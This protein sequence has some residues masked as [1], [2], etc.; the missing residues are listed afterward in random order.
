MSTLLT[1]CLLQGEI[2]NILVD[3]ER[4][5]KIG[6]EVY[7]HTREIDVGGKIV[8]PGMIDLHTH[9]RDMKQSYKEDWI[10]AGRA[11]LQGGVTTVFDMPNTNPPTTDANNYQTKKGY[12]KK[13]SVNFGLYAGATP[14]NYSEMKMFLDEEANV[15]GIKIFLAGSSSNEVVSNTD[16]LTRFF[17][18]ATQYNK[19]VLVHCESQEDIN[20]A[21]EKYQGAM[22]NSVQYHNKIRSTEAAAKA[23]EQVLS[24]AAKVKNKLL[25]LHVSSADEINIIKEYKR[26]CDFPLYCEVT[27]HHLLLNETDLPFCGN[28]GKVN[29]PI[30]TQADNDALWQALAD[31]FIDT[32]GSDHAPHCQTDGRS[33]NRVFLF[34]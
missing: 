12:A 29:P 8:I 28:Y 3:G 33:G 2:T 13:S 11:A 19:P 4:I 30:R 16:L 34:Y 17:I 10:T 31:G 14:E 24:I 18:L 22:Y 9:I 21:L 32:I 25:I 6:R 26:N 15:A 27:P 5:A 20:I 1:N 23:V 7:E